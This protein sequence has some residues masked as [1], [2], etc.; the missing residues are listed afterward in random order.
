MVS[1]HFLLKA[2]Q[3]LEIILKISLKILL[4]V[5][6]YAIFDN[7]ILVEGLFAEALRSLETISFASPIMKNITA[8]FSRFL[9]KLILCIALGSTS[10][11]CCLL[12][13]IAIIL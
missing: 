10:S 2:I 7:F 4:I 1:V 11:A 8:V 5:L 6:F 9:V 13:Y 12:K 3:I